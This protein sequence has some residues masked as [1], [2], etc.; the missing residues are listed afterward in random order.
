MLAQGHAE[1]AADGHVA[2]FRAFAQKHL[3]I[4]KLMAH[5]LAGIPSEEVAA[6]NEGHQFGLAHGGL[7]KDELNRH[8]A[9]VFVVARR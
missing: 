8:Y 7:W 3:A 5:G 9:T 6:C 2:I 1:V 4:D